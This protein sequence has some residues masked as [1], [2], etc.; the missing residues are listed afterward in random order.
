MLRG[1]FIVHKA[2]RL[3]DGRLHFLFR[4]HDGSLA[5]PLETWLTSKA[6][7]V[8]DGRGHCY[9]AGFHVLVGPEAISKFNRLTKGKYVVREVEARD[10]RRKPN[11]RTGIWLARHLRVPSIG[12]NYLVRS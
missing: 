8:M 12:I 2:F 7:V 11:S 6:K 5:V 4:G 9:R 10:I 1:E 3:K